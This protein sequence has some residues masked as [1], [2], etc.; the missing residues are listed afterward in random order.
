MI[1]GAGTR[2]VLKLKIDKV[3]IKSG[4]RRPLH[5]VTIQ[6][7]QEAPFFSEVF[8]CDLQKDPHGNFESITSYHNQNEA[9][10]TRDFYEYLCMK[11]VNVNSNL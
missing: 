8:C 6:S 10:I 9:S 11:I 1:N 4:P 7:F 2:E 3:Q 5:H